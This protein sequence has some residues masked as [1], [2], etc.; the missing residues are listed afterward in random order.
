[1]ERVEPSDRG[2]GTAGDLGYGAHGREGRHDTASTLPRCPAR[3]PEIGGREGASFAAHAEAF[4]LSPARPWGARK[5]QT[6]GPDVPSTEGRRW[7]S[8]GEQG[9]GEEGE[10]RSRGAPGGRKRGAP[11]REARSR[12]LGPAAAPGVG[13]PL[14]A[15]RA[16]AE[17]GGEVRE[18][19]R[20]EPWPR[21]PDPRR[22]GCPGR[23][24]SSRCSGSAG[25]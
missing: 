19:G 5:I 20:A 12:V 23:A 16:V 1:M 6:T 3:G 18:A 21:H 13:R 24:D 9:A 17:P 22:T 15:S 4:T 11:G 25:R 14:D 2:R 10:E 7:G 8:L